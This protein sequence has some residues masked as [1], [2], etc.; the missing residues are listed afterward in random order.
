MKMNY[1]HKSSV[2]KKGLFSLPIKIVMGIVI[3]LAIF[4][5]FLPKALPTFFTTIVKPFW[6]IEQGFLHGETSIDELKRVLNESEISSAQNNALIQEN[7]ALKS[8][9][10]RSPASHSLLATILKRPPSSAYDAFILDVGND[11]GVKKGDKVYAL[12]NIPVGEIAEIIG[13][14]SKVLL[15]SSSG[16]KFNILIGPSSLEATAVGK[17]GG[18]FES[19]LPR[20]TK[21]KVGDYALIPS[22]D[23]AFIGTVESITS[24]PSEPFSKILFRQPLNMY[25]MRWVLVDIN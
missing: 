24:D 13:N 6:N 20:D 1:V 23:N 10:G 18:Y 21:I 22:V 9:L 4:Y 15:Y 17:G 19:S 25:E 16:E 5:I 11:A 14:T 7:E 3:I 12:G 2:S 8:L